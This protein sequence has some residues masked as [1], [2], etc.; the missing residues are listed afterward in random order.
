MVIGYYILSNIIQ[1]LVK[2]KTTDYIIQQ[3]NNT[4]KFKTTDMTGGANIKGFTLSDLKIDIDDIVNAKYV[5]KMIEK[6]E[7]KDIFI[8]YNDDFSNK[9]LLKTKLG[10]NINTDIINSMIQYNANPYIVNKDNMTIIHQLIKYYN[11]KP[12]QDLKRILLILKILI[13]YHQSNL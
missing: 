3:V 7:N 8:W 5:I 10:I 1:E 6:P 2:F 12:I 11:Y 9:D 13:K 4:T